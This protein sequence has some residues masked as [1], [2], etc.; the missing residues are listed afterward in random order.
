[1]LL[2]LCFFCM[3]TISHCSTWAS[4]WF[5]NSAIP[6][7]KE[8]SMFSFPRVVAIIAYVP[9]IG[10]IVNQL[11]AVHYTS[12]QPPPNVMD[13]LVCHT[14]FS[15]I[16]CS[17]YSSFLRWHDCFAARL[18]QAHSF[19]NR[20]GEKSFLLGL[21]ALLPFFLY[22]LSLFLPIVFHAALFCAVLCFDAHS[23]SLCS[24]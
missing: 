19:L 16:P 14:T 11:K 20:A 22:L 6:C 1:M 23:S 3:S 9:W 4:L 12:W 2:L 10:G 17:L 15:A 13:L 18:A 8:D 7:R 24:R 5:L 21:F